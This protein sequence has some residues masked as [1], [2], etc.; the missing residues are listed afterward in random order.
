[1]QNVFPLKVVLNNFLVPS[2]GDLDLGH[3]ADYLSESNFY[4]EKSSV[5]EVIDGLNKSKAFLI[6]LLKG[7]CIVVKFYNIQ[8]ADKETPGFDIETTPTVNQNSQSNQWAG[9]SNSTLIDILSHYSLTQ[10]RPFQVNYDRSNIP[11]G[12]DLIQL[13]QERL[14]QDNTDMPFSS[15]NAFQHARAGRGIFNPTNQRYPG[16]SRGWDFN[17]MMDVCRNLPSYY[18]P[19]RT[20]SEKGNQEGEWPR[21]VGSF[22][23]DDKSAMLKT[24]VNHLMAGLPIAAQ[25]K[26]FS[27]LEL[28]ITKHQEILKSAGKLNFVLHPANNLPKVIFDKIDMIHYTGWYIAVNADDQKWPNTE[29]KV[30]VIS[31]APSW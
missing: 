17:E 29:G 21:A 20:D 22:A 8:T 13:L 30:T 4:K 25:T 5:V 26:V 15:L 2:T 12:M 24:V 6:S 9:L 16:G 31:H 18:S 27:E 11:Q 28:A 10:T 7:T 3:L 23:W 14:M 1:M 19:G